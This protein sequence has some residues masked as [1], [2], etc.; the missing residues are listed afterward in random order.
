[1]VAGGGIAGM[2]AAAHAARAGRTVLV[3]EKAAEIGGSAALS[4]GVVWRPQSKEALATVDPNG[5]RELSDRTIDDYEENIRFVESMGVTVG[6]RVDVLGYGTGHL[7]DII[8]YL[9][10]CGREVERAGGN[11]LTGTVVEELVTDGISVTGCRIKDRDG[12]SDIETKNVILATGGFQADPDARARYLGASGREILLRS[13][14]ESD[15]G[16]L[17]LGQSV[18]G[19]LVDRTD[20][21][22]GHLVA[23]PLQEFGTSD[24]VRLSQM[25]C[26]SGLVIGRNGRRLGDESLGY[27]RSA[28]AAARLENPVVAVVFD[29][30]IHDEMLSQPVGGVK[31]LEVIDRFAEAAAAG[32]VTATADTWE[33]LAAQLEK[34]GFHAESFLQT[35]REF[36]EAMTSHAGGELDPPRKWNRRALDVGPFYAALTQPAVT[37]T[38][39]GLA[40]DLDGRVLRQGGTAIQGLYAAG[41]D[42]GVFA[43]GYGGGLSLGATF[44]RAA[45]HH[46]VARA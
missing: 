26:T 44:G 31:G 21:F 16:G 6:P 43:E 22:Y 45:A 35:V 13:N 25:Q 38:F 34:E 19:Y 5:N 4:G 8:G 11:I 20:G 3:V 15:G 42:G 37:F 24:F 10:A 7:I 46:A 30:A 33:E 14:P 32:G 2:T 23:W 12:L 9:R 1:M 18:G 28:Q 41:G 17:R 39:G 27:A 29:Q 40:I 36:N